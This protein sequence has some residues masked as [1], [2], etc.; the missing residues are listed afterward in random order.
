F[1]TKTGIQ[2]RLTS[3]GEGGSGNYHSCG[4]RSN[5][6]EMNSGAQVNCRESSVHVTLY[7]LWTDF[8]SLAVFYGGNFEDNY[9]WAALLGMYQEC[10]ED[11]ETRKIFR[12]ILRLNNKQFND[13]IRGTRKL[14][15]IHFLEY[16]IWVITNS[17]GRLPP[18]VEKDD[19]I[20]YFQYYLCQET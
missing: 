6:L 10:K 3:A 17:Q 15:I 4:Y 12:S 1:R 8:C 9:V 18:F 13:M 19:Q 2:C 7:P 5:F 20:Q 16:V 14:V 11:E